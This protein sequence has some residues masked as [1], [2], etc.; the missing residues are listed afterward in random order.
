M[1]DTTPKTGAADPQP[2]E[3]TAE[4]WTG[5]ELEAHKKEV[6]GIPGFYAVKHPDGSGG[7]GYN[8]NI[9]PGSPG[10][11]WER[12]GNILSIIQQHSAEIIENAK[13]GVYATKEEKYAKAAYYKNFAA[14]C[15]GLGAHC[16]DYLQFVHEE[17]NRTK[18]GF[19]GK[20]FNYFFEFV[21]VYE[22]LIE[23][24]RLPKTGETILQEEKDRLKELI[25][26]EFAPSVKAEEEQAAEILDLW[27]GNIASSNP[28]TTRLTTNK[29][30][31]SQLQIAAKGKEGKPLKIKVGNGAL[32]TA[33]I[34]PPS[35]QTGSIT[36]PEQLGLTEYD[37]E[38][39]ESI[40]S[41]YDAADP[42]Q[43][44]F[45]LAQIY[46]EFAGITK[47]VKVT[48]KEEAEVEAAIEK[49]RL[50][51][52]KIDFIDQAKKHKGLN[53]KQEDALLEG[54]VVN[55]TKM[56]G[57]AGGHKV[58]GYYIGFPPLYYYYSKLM[59]QITQI[60]K[61]LLN[62]TDTRRNTQNFIVLKRKLIKQIEY[63]RSEKEKNKGRY[64]K[65]RSYSTIYELMGLKD[66]PEAVTRIIKKDIDTLLTQWASGKR[67]YI[68]SFKKYKGAGKTIAGIEI[69][70]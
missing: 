1:A 50:L 33:S 49:M 25:A 56:R 38:L 6:D 51:T 32:V 21:F 41:L 26:A 42:G 5:E 43:T 7:Y 12:R 3:W 20:G 45:T 37:I 11:T 48:K 16:Q 61:K 52:A 8:D 40:G 66:P 19:E 14:N 63:M 59:G 67:K 24:G 36:K 62:T 22:L 2:E 23:Q 27:E 53:I 29:V 35:M 4:T 30:A 57:T 10:D 68:K 9:S 46:R 18:P 58:D 28:K 70:I 39:E 55:A 31:R 54:Y 34:Y 44:F 60:D 47:T 17:I 13:S 64:E 15:P 69:E 65:R